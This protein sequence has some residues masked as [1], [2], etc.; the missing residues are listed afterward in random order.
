[1]KAKIFFLVLYFIGLVVVSGCGHTPDE[2]GSPL[3]WAR[4]ESWEGQFKGAP[5]MNY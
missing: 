2:G 3:P 5:S 4:P 1:M